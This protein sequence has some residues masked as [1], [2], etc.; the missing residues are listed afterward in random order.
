MAVAPPEQAVINVAF[1]PAKPKAEAI[2]SAEEAQNKEA[3]RENRA[4][5]PLLFKKF[6]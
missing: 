4:R 6:A 2:R 1:G 3:S 5:R